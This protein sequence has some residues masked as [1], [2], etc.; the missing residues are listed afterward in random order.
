[1]N[2]KARSTGLK[3]N[4]KRF[5]Q[6]RSG[7]GQRKITQLAAQVRGCWSRFATISVF[8]EVTPVTLPPGR[9]RLGTRP[10]ATGSLPAA[11]TIGMTLVAALAARAASVLPGVAITLTC[12]RIKSAASSGSLFVCRLP[13]D[14]RLRRF[15]LRQSPLHLS[16]SGRRP[17][18]HD[19]APANLSA[20]SQSL[21]PGLSVVHVRGKATRPRCRQKKRNEVAPIHVSS[22][23]TRT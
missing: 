23:R 3:L 8:N 5:R 15:G 6:Y 22:G 7:I 11:K 17:G 12:R 10:R 18:D 16:L 13:S 4:D 20:T 19:S 2:S 14:T 1:M 9:L 21:V